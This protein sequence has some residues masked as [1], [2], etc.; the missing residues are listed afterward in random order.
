MKN[1]L[2]WAIT[3]LGIATLVWVCSLLIESKDALK[4][5][6]TKGQVISSLLIIDHL[7]KFIDREDDPMRWYGADIQYEYSV[8]DMTYISNRVSPHDGY[9]RNPKNILRV[10]NKYR[11]QHEVSVYYD[12]ADP[13]KAML[14]PANVGGIFIPL[15]IGGLVSFLGLFFIYQRSL[16][17]N[18]QGTENYLH[19]GRVYQRRGKFEEALIE[20]NRV[21]EMNP[22]LVMG[23]IGRGGLYLQQEHWDLAIADFDQA[24]S[25]APD[26]GPVYFSRANAYIGKKEWHMAME[27]MLKAVE[28]GYIVNPEIFENIQKNFYTLQS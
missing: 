5:P 10:L 20:F 12:P 26:L 9:A 11:H 15:I 17:L 8:G 21:I 28:M 24:L 16:E 18:L 1:S 14:E 27:D 19:Q 22:R 2:L 6:Q 4:W 25:I 7:P 3:L 13:Q 23:Y